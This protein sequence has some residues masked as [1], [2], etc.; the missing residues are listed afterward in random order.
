M[1]AIDPALGVKLVYLLGIT[2]VISFLLV[3]LT[4]RCMIG[5]KFVNDM[6]K[7]PWYR[8]LFDHHCW[9]WRLFFL[10]VIIHITLALL[11]FGIPF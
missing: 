3:A 4:C 5:V 7:K 1:T 11:V 9:Y 10:S 2:N 8:W 6:L